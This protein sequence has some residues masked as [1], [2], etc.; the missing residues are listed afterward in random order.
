MDKARKQRLLGVLALVVLF[1]VYVGWSERPR[2]LL[3]YSGQASAPIAYSYKEQGVETFSG[4]I[5]PGQVREF[6][7]KL[8]GGSDYRIA[9]SF[10]RGEEKYA[11][12]STKPGWGTLD[13]YVDTELSVSTQPPPE[14]LIQQQ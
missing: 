10:H 5:R 3:H 8:F 7:V 9:F 4:E 1:G 11:S 12:F 6:P 2:I 14:G 13:L